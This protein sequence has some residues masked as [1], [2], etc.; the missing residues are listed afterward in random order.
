MQKQLNKIY[1]RFNGIIIGS[2]VFGTFFPTLLIAQVPQDP[3][4]PLSLEKKW[5]D[6]LSGSGLVRF[7]SF[8]PTVDLI[9]MGRKVIFA[10]FSGIYELNLDTGEIRQF[11]PG[12]TPGLTTRTIL[13]VE[14]DSQGA[15]WFGSEGGLIKWHQ[16]TWSIFTTANSPLP[17]NIVRSLK[18]DKPGI[19]IGTY[20]GVIYYDGKTWKTFDQLN[21]TLPEK[22]I[23]AIEIDQRGNKWFG[24]WG[25]GIVRFD[26]TNATIWNTNGL[27]YVTGIT[28]DS[29]NN[30]WV[31]T[32][33][34][35]ENGNYQGGGLHKFDGATRV[36]YH[37]GNS[38]LPSRN[39]RT[40]AVDKSD[41]IWVAML[42]WRDLTAWG[43]A[44]F[45]GTQWQTFD[46]SNSGLSDNEISAIAVDAENNKWL[47]MK[48]GIEKFD[49]NTWSTFKTYFSNNALGLSIVVDK[50][51]KKWTADTESLLMMEA[52]DEQLGKID[53]F[54]YKIFNSPH[55]L[56][57]HTL[58]IDSTGIFW[59]G[60]SRRLV[61]FD[62]RNWKAFNPTSQA[63][64]GTMVINRIEVD[65]KNNKWIWLKH[66][67]PDSTRPVFLR[68][69]GSSWQVYNLPNWVRKV[70]SFA[71]DRTEALWI[72]TTTGLV[73]FDGTT[74][75]LYDITNSG[76]RAN[77]VVR[78]F[79]DKVN[80]KWMSVYDSNLYGVVRYDGIRWDFYSTHLPND[81]AH[82]DNLP[83]CFAT[84][85][86]G[87]IWIG[88]M[89]LGIVGA[90]MKFENSK[91][92]VVLDRYL[93]PV[94]NVVID[95][96]NNLWLSDY[97]SGIWAYFETLSTEVNDRN[98]IVQDLWEG[99]TLYPNYP[100]PFNG[101]TAIEFRLQRADHVELIIYDIFG[102]IVKVLDRGFRGTGHY[103]IIWDGKDEKARPVSSGIYYGVLSIGRNVKSQKML[104]LK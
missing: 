36:I 50:L 68:Y 90:I 60:G 70:T 59:V 94:L 31:A 1:M 73:R 55:Q 91:L 98:E 28:V 24:T 61:R 3:L 11:V 49:G 88:T 58:T 85:S 87:T 29:K 84:N 65:R 35:H 96:N 4:I 22:K 103:R 82:V 56:L 80:A 34:T 93:G 30:V 64:L 21:A 44:S 26:G 43:L 42:D 19:W 101:D 9:R 76:L 2:V 5:D 102:R 63:L 45:D 27:Q 66:S 77:T 15:I 12:I 75:T 74:T 71:V 38:G 72:G 47:G 6:Q 14:V 69:D 40:I 17:T 78:V 46:R 41:V 25:K 52:S 67:N 95:K 92:T 23:M 16:N 51:D 48:K 13:D 57:P 8:G 86:S 104:L 39:I 79:V 32:Y 97:S 18:A 81:P 7:P 83:L 53:H 100:N 62:G 89:R 20:N 99:F 33:A 37:L 10:S 54:R